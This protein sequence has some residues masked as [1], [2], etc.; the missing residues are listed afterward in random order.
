[1]SFHFII[2][3]FFFV[4][5]F[6]FFQ[7]YFEVNFKFFYTKYLIFMD[8][9]KKVKKQISRLVFICPFFTVNF[10]RRS[11]LRYFYEL[12]KKIFNLFSQWQKKKFILNYAGMWIYL[13]YFV[14]LFCFL[15][16]LSFFF[17]F[18]ISCFVPVLF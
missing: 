1:M 4:C 9:K 16:F 10:I 14:L 12:K 17:F 11:L 15:L 5:V 8:P 3:L 13:F 18:L 2:Y 6:F 7:Y